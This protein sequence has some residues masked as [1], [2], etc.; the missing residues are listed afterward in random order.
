MSILEIFYYKGQEER[1]YFRHCFQII[2]NTLDFTS[3][4]LYLYLF[5]TN[6][7]IFGPSW[8]PTDVQ[9]FKVAVTCYSQQQAWSEMRNLQDFE[10]WHVM[11]LRDY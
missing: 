4:M 5:F 7:C 1:N 2:P 6:L 9:K 10:P 8:P 11:R 3:N